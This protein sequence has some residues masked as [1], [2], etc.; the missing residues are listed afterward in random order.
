M[1]PGVEVPD[2]CMESTQYVA[3]ILAGPPQPQLLTNRVVPP[4]VEGKAWPKPRERDEKVKETWKDRQS[5]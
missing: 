2:Q 5:K 1:T 3:R 4:T